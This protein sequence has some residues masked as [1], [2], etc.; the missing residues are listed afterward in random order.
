MI[1]F[2]GPKNRQRFLCEVRVPSEAYVGAGNS[3]NKKDAERNAA[4][5]FVNYL[6]RTGKVASS[7]VPS[8]SDNGVGGGDGG[9]SAPASGGPPSL[10]NINPA[11][12]FQSGFGPSDLGQAYRPFIR[13]NTYTPSKEELA[14]QEAIMESAESLDVNAGIH[15][16][17]TIENAKAKLNQWLQ[18]NRMN[19]DY[20]YTAVGPDHAR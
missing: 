11:R 20:K 2:A 4:R 15:G 5:D 1:Q 18:M 10:M 13:D 8:E 7:D 9:D 19:P 6:V 12:V 17:W 14:E 3:T 16:N